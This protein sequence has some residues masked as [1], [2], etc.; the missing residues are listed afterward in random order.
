MRG[1]YF[2][3]LFVVIFLIRT[4]SGTT[5]ETTHDDDGGQMGEGLLGLLGKKNISSADP[6]PVDE[7]HTDSARIPAKKVSQTTNPVILRAASLMLAPYH[8][9]MPPHNPRHSSLIKHSGFIPELLLKLERKLEGR[10]PVK[11]EMYMPSDP[12]FGTLTNES[13]NGLIGQLIKKTQ[14]SEG[15]DIAAF[16]IAMTAERQK[17]VTF[18]NPFK[19]GG[20]TAIFKKPHLDNRTRDPIE[21][22]YF[23]V[24]RPLGTDVWIVILAGCLMVSGL[25]WLLNL[26]NPNEWGSLY[27][28]GRASEAA[29]ESFNLPGSLWFT[30]TTLQWQGFDRMPRSLSSKVL[31]LF[32]FTFVSVSMMMYTAAV[33]NNVFWASTYHGRDLRVQPFSDIPHLIWDHEQLGYDYGLVI[34]GSAFSYLMNA[35]G[36]QYNIMRKYWTSQGQKHLAYSIEDG[37]ARARNGKYALITDTMLASYYVNQKPCEL[38]MLQQPLGQRSYGMAVRKNLDPALLEALRV[39]ILEMTENGEI[40]AMEQ[41]WW[42]DMGECWNE[43]EAEAEFSSV[44]SLLLNTPKQITFS[45]FWGPL[46]IISFGVLISI[47]IGVA[48]MIYFA[49]KGKY[50]RSNLP[51]GRRLGQ[52][53]TG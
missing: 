27:N 41:K 33:V 26:F 50:Q 7:E 24:M 40:D 48:E 51:G 34:N 25:F 19:H 21:S 30:F 31:A 13:W 6:G 29:G 52:E 4:S 23:N 38:T 53:D 22:T 44:S 15:A 39:A 32:W 43:T 37:L 16:P 28:K 12:H 49:Q 47:C 10:Y 35:K 3:L 1:V 42:D 2:S 11:F 18:L 9:S 36:P 8:M 46:L 20:L 14:G 5:A 45:M 17:V